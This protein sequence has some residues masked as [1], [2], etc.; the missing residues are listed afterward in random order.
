MKVEMIVPAESEFLVVRM[1]Q[2]DFFIL[3]GEVMT[4]SIAMLCVNFNQ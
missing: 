1:D 4:L 2:A 3:C